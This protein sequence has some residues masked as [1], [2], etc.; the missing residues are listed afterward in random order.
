MA[1]SEATT[2]LLGEGAE[3]ADQL[4]SLS[5][6]G[7]NVIPFV[8]GIAAWEGLAPRH[9]CVAVKRK[10]LLDAIVVIWVNNGADIEVS[11]ASKA[12]EADL[13]K[14]AWDIG[15]TLTDRVPVADPTSWEGLVGSL[16]T[17]N[18]ELG[19]CFETS[20]LGEDNCALGRVLVDKVHRAS[21]GSGRKEQEA[22][23]LHVGWLV[24]DLR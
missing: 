24:V 7:L 8:V 2:A 23:E 14:H 10:D 20:V 22:G 11:C 5:G 18:G 9:R 17:S 15:S 4:A 6:L 3:Q 12:I 21:K 19:N 1:Y 13:S 16:E